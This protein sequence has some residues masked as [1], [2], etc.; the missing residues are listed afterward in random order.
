MNASASTRVWPLEGVRIVDLTRNVAGPYA[1]MILAE[2]GADVVKVERPDRGDD[3]RAWGPP[4]WNE[5]STVYLSLN[6]NKRSICLDLSDASGRDAVNRLIA[7]SDVLIESFRPGALDAM[8]LG[9]ESVAATN[10]RL[11]YCSVTPFGQTGPLRDRPG[12]D[13]MM[14]AYGGL[15][16]VTGEPGRPP[17]R[18]GVSIIDMGTGMWAALA[19]MAAL[20]RR[21][22]TGRGDRVV[23]ALYETALAWMAYHLATYWASGEPPGRYGSGAFSMV[24]YSAFETADG[25]LVISAPNDALFRLLCRA[26]GIPDLA[27]DERFGTNPDRVRNRH[28]LEAILAER[29]KTWPSDALAA[30]LDGVGVPN[31][32]L[33]TVDRVAADPQAAALGIFQSI[34]HPSVPDFR[35]VGLPFLLN[36]R[37]PEL[38]SAPPMLGE[39]TRQVLEE[40]GYGEPE[41]D[42]LLSR[43][44][45]APRAA[46][47]R[48]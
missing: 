10:P 44:E 46:E 7:R 16:S 38:R 40:L 5:E 11:I 3:T 20:M 28:E 25:Y 8:G 18:V 45:A 4:F 36:D 47:R 22:E 12:Y 26:L 17:V 27:D 9:Y 30:A 43:Q 23:V 32:Q 35:S 31:I 33:N 37:R 34:A 24:P 48:L 41:I 6:R 15:M 21:A 2:L 42:Q 14:Q 1:S 39:H 19:V 29:T 13:P